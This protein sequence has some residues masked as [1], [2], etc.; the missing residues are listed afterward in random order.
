MTTTDV[1]LTHFRALAEFEVL[2]YRA[3]KITI[4][5]KRISPDTENHDKNGYA[6]VYDDNNIFMT[7]VDNN[8][9]D[10]TYTN[11]HKNTDYNMRDMDEW[12][13]LRTV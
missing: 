4:R 11:K 13:H 12:A 8:N 10:T 1:L 7:N 5:L 3:K 9:S 2:W 6:K